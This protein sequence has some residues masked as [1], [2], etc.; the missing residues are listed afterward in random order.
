MRNLLIALIPAALIAG[1]ACAQEAQET[2]A[3]PAEPAG[4]QA[5]ERAP[6]LD[7]E[8]TAITGS[9]VRTTTGV[10]DT[11]SY[12]SEEGEELFSATCMAAD[13]ETGDRIVQ[14]R[15]V[16]AEDTVGAIDM[17]TSA[18]NARLPA[19]PDA[20]A[21]LASG[22]T[23]PVSRPTYVLAS[24]AGDMRIVSGTRG[25]IFQTDPML[26]DLIRSCQPDYLASLRQR[27]AAEAEQEAE[28]AEEVGR[29]S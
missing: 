2:Q 7:V 8:T 24:G 25:V 11:V 21:D 13:T 12:T 3:L 28:T 5:A 17:F 9:W 15:A 29:A 14:I 4:E 16:S 22:L 10:R 26:K 19:A 1:A 18:G 6:P 23:E 27:A 20:S